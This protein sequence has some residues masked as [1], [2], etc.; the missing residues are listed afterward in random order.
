M[1]ALTVLSYE[2]LRVCRPKRTGARAAKVKLN[3][4]FEVKE[5]IK[6]VSER[7]QVQKVCSLQG[8]NILKA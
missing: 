1:S 2:T 4:H 3:K 7:A 5:V 8:A 6:S